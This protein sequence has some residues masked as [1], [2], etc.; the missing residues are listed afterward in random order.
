ERR[1]ELGF[2][3]LDAPAP[4]PVGEAI[5]PPSSG[6]P[7]DE[8]RAALPDPAG[9]ADSPPQEV[10]LEFGFEELPSHVLAQALTQVRTALTDTLAASRLEHG[11]ITVEGTPRRIV[12]T[13][14]DVSAIEPDAAVFRK[15]PRVSAAFDAE[16]R[17]TRAAEGF[18]RGQKVSVDDLTRM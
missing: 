2:P 5:M 3:L 12:A 16:G 11:D 8:A 13:V 17:S 4:E 15:G 6:M 18:A 10:A 1:E 7:D 14:A 9:L